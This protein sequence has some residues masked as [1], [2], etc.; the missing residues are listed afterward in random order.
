MQLCA[1]S[2]AAS[3]RMGAPGA[4]CPPCVA[5]PVTCALSAAASAGAAVSCRRQAREAAAVCCVAGRGAAQPDGARAAGGRPASVRGQRQRRRGQRGRRR[6]GGAARGQQPA[7]GRGRGG[8]AVAA[9]AAAGAGQGGAGPRRRVRLVPG[10]QAARAHP[11]GAP[12]ARQGE[13]PARA[14]RSWCGQLRLAGTVRCVP[15]HAHTCLVSAQPSVALFAPLVEQG[16]PG[17]GS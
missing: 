1:R 10:R 11:A 6:G 12:A 16:K 17:A 2:R 15:H 9:V 13:G 5:S 4:A 8:G 7:R 14:E 3:R